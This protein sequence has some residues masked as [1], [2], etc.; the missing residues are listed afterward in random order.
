ME[1][2]LRI[3]TPLLV[4]ALLSGCATEQRP[5]VPPLVHLPAAPAAAGSA[6]SGTI[7]DRTMLV[8]SVPGGAIIVVDGRPVG[9]APV[10]LSV[11]ATSQG[12]FQ[13]YVEVRARFIAAADGQDGHTTVVSFSPLEKVPVAL[14][15]TPT[16][17]RRS[18]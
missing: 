7:T 14:R 6:T 15:L 4:L 11:P 2:P 1:H 13:G 3:S 10:R 18:W 5:A 17:S 9:K 8:E 12:F 16:G